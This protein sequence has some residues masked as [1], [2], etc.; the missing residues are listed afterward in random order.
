MANRLSNSSQIGCIDCE[1]IV[2]FNIAS[3]LIDVVANWT[4]VEE[5]EDNPND[6]TIEE[7]QKVTY[8]LNRLFGTAYN[9]NYIID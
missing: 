5:G 7:M 8:A 3:S 2:K 4:M 1:D 9:I 6:L